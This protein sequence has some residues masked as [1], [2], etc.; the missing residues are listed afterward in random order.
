MI[1]E[2]DQIFDKLVGNLWIIY[3]DAAGD[4][5]YDI[6]L[7]NPISIYKYSMNF[8]DEQ[9]KEYIYRK[10]HDLWKDN[11]VMRNGKKNENI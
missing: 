8:R 1:T 6:E 2:E 7:S 10:T 5:F 4:E 11:H 9:F 3:C